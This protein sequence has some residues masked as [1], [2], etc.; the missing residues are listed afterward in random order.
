M[1]T[2]LKEKE[3]YMYKNYLLALVV[4]TLTFSGCSDDADQLSN[5]S[6]NFWYQ[7]LVKS[8]AISNLDQA[9]DY[10]SS[11]HSEHVSSPLLPQ[12]MLMLSNAHARFDE[13]LLSQYYLDE[14]LKRF[15]D[16]LEREYVEFLKVKSTFLNYRHPNRNQKFLDETIETIGKFTLKFPES[17]YLP[18]VH[19][20]LLRLELGRDMLKEE[21]A[22]LYE[23]I[24][25]PKG[26]EYYRNKS[27][28][29][30][31]AADDIKAPESSWMRQLFE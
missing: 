28:I 1:V 12:A 6:A 7:K 5:K 29:Q 20:M 19:H 11:L 8:I 16:D 25:K 22:K 26:V 27:R 21:I 24:D 15:G 17:T 3:I 10:Y 30:G 14:Y 2:N 31:M 23:R 4:V 13:L 18:V 9:D